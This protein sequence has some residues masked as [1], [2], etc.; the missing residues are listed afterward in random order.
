MNSVAAKNGPDVQFVKKAL[1]VTTLQVQ[2]SIGMDAGDARIIQML[3][4]AH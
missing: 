2:T 3:K 4:V 1:D